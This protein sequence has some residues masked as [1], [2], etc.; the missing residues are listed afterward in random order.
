MN[1]QNDFKASLHIDSKVGEDSV[2]FQVGLGQ[3]L[4]LQEQHLLP[5]LQPSR[6]RRRQRRAEARKVAEEV[7][8]SAEEADL[9]VD[10]AV[11]AS[12]SSTVDKIVKVSQKEEIVVAEKDT[13]NVVEKASKDSAA[14]EMVE[15]VSVTEDE[16]CYFCISRV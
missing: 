11:Q 2:S 14:P 1:W 12:K 7:A 5:K 8:K 16:I 4:P 9:G 6:L 10:S 15:T 13:I 3:A